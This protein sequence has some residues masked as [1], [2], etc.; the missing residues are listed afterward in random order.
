MYI[1]YGGPGKTYAYACVSREVNGKN[2]KEQQ[3]YLGRVLDRERH[4]FR[5]KERGTFVF[6]P[7]T[8]EYTEASVDATKAHNII[9]ICGSHRR[10]SGS[11]ST[12]YFPGNDGK[13]NPVT[14]G[15]SALQIKP[16]RRHAAHHRRALC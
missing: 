6:N 15:P 10:S 13:R 5:S 7:E 9:N 4:I 2:I 3:I 14:P 8:G 12:G 1:N 11:F 16:G